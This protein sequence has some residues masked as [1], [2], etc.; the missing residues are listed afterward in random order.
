MGMDRVLLTVQK[1][2]LPSQKVILAN[3]GELEK[4]SEKYRYD[5][6]EL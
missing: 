2:N 3:D 5:W 4:E 1:G 6:I